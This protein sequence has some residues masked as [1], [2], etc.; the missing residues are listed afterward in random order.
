[1]N[2]EI[3]AIGG[4]DVKILGGIKSGI[5]TFLFPKSNNKEYNEWKKKYE[6]HKKYDKIKFVE[7]SSIKDVFDYVF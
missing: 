4:L 5:T 6:K 7:V 1:L 2:G 3:T